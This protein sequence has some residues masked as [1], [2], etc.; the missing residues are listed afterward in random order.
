MTWKENNLG[1]E[2]NNLQQGEE[3]DFHNKKKRLPHYLNKT[4]SK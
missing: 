1:R 4:V 2:Q 3:D